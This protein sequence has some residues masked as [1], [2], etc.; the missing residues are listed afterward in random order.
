MTNKN[1]RCT[2]CTWRGS[3]DEAIAAPRVRRS[4]IPPAMEQLQAAYEEAQAT[5]SEMLG[6]PKMPPCPACGHH[7]TGVQKRASVVPSAS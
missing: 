2:V 4:D 5:N 3:L 1:V 7:L 6:M